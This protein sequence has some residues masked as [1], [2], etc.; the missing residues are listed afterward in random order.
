MDQNYFDIFVLQRVY[1]LTEITAVDNSINT[2]HS[3]PSSSAA[4]HH[5]HDHSTM[6]MSLVLQPKEGGFFNN[7]L[8]A[9]YFWGEIKN[10]SLGQNKK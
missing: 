8:W 10:V 9:L 5:D 4:A 2:N 7:L 3:S 1:V 6:P